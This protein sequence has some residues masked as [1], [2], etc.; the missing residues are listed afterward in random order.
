MTTSNHP[1][2]HRA[3]LLMIGI[4]LWLPCANGFAQSNN[5][6]K[7]DYGQ[8]Q[9]ER[10]RQSVNG[11]SVFAEMFR[12][13][14]RKV[15]F[16]SRISE[17]VKKHKTIVWFPDKFGGPSR[18]VEVEL[19]KWLDEDPEHVLIY[20]GRDFDAELM[21][22]MNARATIPANQKADL[23][24]QIQ[25][26]KGRWE[27]R[28]HQSF[29]ETN[30]FSVVRMHDMQRVRSFQGSW[31]SLIVPSRTEIY[32]T[33]QWD[34]PNRT[35]YKYTTTHLLADGN[36]GD[37]IITELELNSFTGGRIIVCQNGSSLLNLPLV[38][39]ENRKIAGLLINETAH[40]SVLFLDSGFGDPE[41]ANQDQEAMTIWSWATKKPLCYMVPHFVLLGIVFCFAYFPIF[42]RGKKYRAESNTDFAL[43]L[44]ATAQ[45]LE[46]SKNR[47]LAEQKINYAHSVLEKKN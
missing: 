6:I 44:Q 10:F 30:W 22:W 40:G 8:A 27:G 41:I 21:Y 24:R 38:N 4:T 23:E 34:I 20:V 29:E 9:D 42:G 15:Y 11:S 35:A 28:R 45:L 33:A 3:V 25:R 7:S 19:E 18:E 31:S 37:P 2:I 13:S 1:V 26:I 39:P 5:P 43:H 12:D 46:H 17:R 47:R 16:A 36:T 14:G 32:T